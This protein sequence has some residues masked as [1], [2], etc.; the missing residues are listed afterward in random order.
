MVILG[1]D[2]IGFMLF[3]GLERAGGYSLLLSALPSQENI[4][5]KQCPAHEPGL[6]DIFPILGLMRKELLPSCQR[7]RF[8]INK[9]LF[10]LAHLR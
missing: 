6:G 4:G 8:L 10:I 1:S 3:D 5:E 7:S 2:D 9:E